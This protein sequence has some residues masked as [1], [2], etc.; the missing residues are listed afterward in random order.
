[1]SFFMPKIKKK[2]AEVP[3]S[4]GIISTCAPLRLVG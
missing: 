2:E 1:M 4:I 3:E